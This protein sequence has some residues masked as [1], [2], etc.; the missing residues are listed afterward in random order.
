MDYGK[1]ITQ[2]GQGWADLLKPFM[3]KDDANEI[4]E[5]QKIVTFLQEQK[6]NQV[7]TYPANKDIYKAFRAT[8]LEKVR[9]VLLGQDPY[10]K[11]GYANGLA[12]ATDMAKTPVSLE[13]M[14]DGIENDVYNGIN[15]D[16]KLRPND[17]ISWTEQGVLLLN[18]SLTVED[19][20]PNS[21]A[22]TWEPFTKFLVNNL[23]NVK[24]DLVWIGL[25]AP[26]KKF[27]DE[28]NP[29]RSFV[30]L[31]EHPSAAAHAKRKWN[32]NNVFTKTNMALSLNN[33]GEPIKW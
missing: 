21:H 33:L 9:V 26:A 1:L 16:R 22:K 3:V 18:T 8:P 14:Y 13:V 7:V 15:F 10:P 28:V 12:F 24:R 20:K 25:G 6:S 27:L 4:V 23:A 2:V 32:H 19:S 17:L 29:F 30:F 11:A 31:A 5:Y